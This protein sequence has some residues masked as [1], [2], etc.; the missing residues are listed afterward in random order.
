MTKADTNGRAALSLD[1]EK[2]VDL[3]VAGTDTQEAA[4]ALGVTRQ[5][6]SRW[7]NH[8]AEFR[9]ALNA[10]RLEVWGAAADRL[11]NLLPRAVAVVEGAL[12]VDPDPKLALEVLKLAGVGAEVLRGDAPTDPE[13]IRARDAQRRSD[14][15]LALL[16]AGLPMR[17]RA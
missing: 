5:T 2:A 12:A 17:P 6:V 7:L 13:D 15:E 9:A 16:M 11:R 10:R 8:D 14:R 1:Q 4:D 3:L